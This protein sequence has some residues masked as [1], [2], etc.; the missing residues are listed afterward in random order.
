LSAYLHLTGEQG[1]PAGVAMIET[2][3]Q[4]KPPPG[5]GDIVAFLKGFKLPGEIV[6]DA[7]A[8]ASVRRLLADTQT[9]PRPFT[10]RDNLK[11]AMQPFVPRDLPMMSR[12]AQ[13]AALRRL[14]ADIK[15]AKLELWR[16]KQVSDF[17]SGIWAQG[18]GQIYVDGIEWL[19]RIRAVA[20]VV[21]AVT[22]LLF[23]WML[24]RSRRLG[25]PRPTDI[26][27][28]ARARGP[29]SQPDEASVSG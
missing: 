23:C 4:H 5:D 10:I 20:R 21:F 16:T 27:T 22:I 14:D 9:P 29:L 25:P 12:D 24:W 17:L 19:M 11:A 3:A 2:L 7:G 13:A 6:A 15:A 8:I 28:R 26:D 18:Y 1:I